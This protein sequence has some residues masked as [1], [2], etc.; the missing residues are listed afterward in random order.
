MTCDENYYFLIHG[1]IEALAFEAWEYTSSA[2]I[3][4][5]YTCISIV[6]YTWNTKKKY[7]TWRR[8]KHV[9]LK[10]LYTS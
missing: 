10:G 7:F 5:K 3:Q 4:V 9:Y 6:T 2:D 1:V 8:K